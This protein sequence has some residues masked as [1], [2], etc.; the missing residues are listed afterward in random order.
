MTSKILIM[1]LPGAGKTTLAGTLAPLLQAIVFNGDEVRSGIS[2]DLGFSHQDR[3][4]HARRM[5]RLCD[6]VVE[7]GGI[8]IADFI[9]PTPETRAAFG[10]AFVIWVDRIREGRYADT[11][12]LFVPP[13]TCD[14]RVT[15]D[16]TPRYWAERIVARLRP[17]LVA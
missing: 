10:N 1:G 8:A 5:G 16:G 9:C 6:H 11:N 17:G 14:E 13:A 12:S 4:E 2:R 15:A 3:I 7:T